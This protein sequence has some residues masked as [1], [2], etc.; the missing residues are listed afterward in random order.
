MTN[1]LLRL[2]TLILDLTMLVLLLAA[3]VPK[4]GTTRPRNERQA[5]TPGKGMNVDFMQPSP[6]FVR[7]EERRNR[8]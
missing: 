4:Q 3:P 7:V 6:A 1:R 5:Y 2:W 8:R